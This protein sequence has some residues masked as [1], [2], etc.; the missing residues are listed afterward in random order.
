M[1]E[2]NWQFQIQSNYQS[3][4]DWI[5]HESLNENEINWIDWLNHTQS[6]VRWLWLTSL[7]GS[8]S[9]VSDC[10]WLSGVSEW[11]NQW[12]TVRVTL[13]D[14]Q[15]HSH[16]LSLTLTVPSAS[17]QWLTVTMSLT[18]SVNQWRVVRNYVPCIRYPWNYAPVPSKLCT[19]TLETM[20]P[21]RCTPS[22][23]LCTL[24]KKME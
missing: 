1:S 6:Y 8:E 15:W 12:V 11:L 4:N 17:V 20:L 23:K 10:E 9:R 16:W 22:S 7:T 13:S 5:N 14:W 21:I 2:S 18:R 24:Y 3:T 19:H